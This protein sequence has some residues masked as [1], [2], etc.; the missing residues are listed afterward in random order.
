[1]I[2]FA[3]I[4]V[5]SALCAVAT[6]MLALT[7]RPGEEVI[8]VFAPWVDEQ[9]IPARIWRSG[10]FATAQLDFGVAASSGSATFFTDLRRNGALFVLSAERAAALCGDEKRT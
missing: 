10:G 2:D 4:F 3:K 9:S 1:M 5:L 6:T 8:V 7:P